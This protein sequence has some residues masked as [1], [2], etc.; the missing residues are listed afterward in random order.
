L[1]NIS[2]SPREVDELELAVCGANLSVR[3]D[4]FAD[5]VTVDV[6]D[7]AEIE[8]DLAVSGIQKFADDSPQGRPTVSED[9]FAAQVNHRDV[10]GLTPCLQ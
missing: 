8:N 7:I 6:V 2:Q 9:D 5:S 1:K 3:C 10:T 4:H